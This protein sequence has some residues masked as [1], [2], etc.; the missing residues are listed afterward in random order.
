ME[1]Y[2]SSE[3]H[4]R[5]LRMYQSFLGRSPDVGGAN[6]WIDRYEKGLSLSRIGQ[7][8]EGSIEFQQ[9]Y[10]TL[11]DADFLRTVYQNVLGRFP[12]AGGF[13]YWLA[14]LIGE[15]LPRWRL[16]DFFSDSDEFRLRNPYPLSHF[17]EFVTA[18]RLNG[19]GHARPHNQIAPGVEYLR[20]NTDTH[21]VFIDP[22]A[23]GSLDVSGGARGRQVGY[24]GG[25]A[26]INGN[27]FGGYLPH[28]FAGYSVSNG[29]ALG[30]VDGDK[31]LGWIGETVD[32]RWEFGPYNGQNIPPDAEEAVSGKILVQNGLKNPYST[33]RTND[34]TMLRRDPRSGLGLRHDD[35]LIMACVNGR[36]YGRG[37]TASALADLFIEFGCEH[38]LILDG[39]GSSTLYTSKLGIMNSPSDGSPRR[40]SNQM[41]YRS[42]G[43]WVK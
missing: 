5:I 28:W 9:R 30:S 41:M 21:L 31:R 37:M 29:K 35:I 32:D 7:H 39:G 17:S 10:G 40:V 27:W 20:Y 42:E 36:R 8:F 43:E 12:D 4:R 38:A 16:I 19:S 25:S 11:D 23:S 6:Y 33:T 1:I 24:Y 13:Q 3:E 34:P 14:R 26:A 2:S 15:K 22:Q 18:A